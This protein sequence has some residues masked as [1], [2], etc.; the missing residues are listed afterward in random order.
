VM[1]AAPVAAAAADGDTMARESGTIVVPC[2][3]DGCSSGHWMDLGL[4]DAGGDAARVSPCQVS[5][6]PGSCMLGHGW[7]SE[8]ACPCSGDASGGP[9]HV[10]R[11]AEVE[12]D[13]HCTPVRQRSLP[14][15]PVSSVYNHSVSFFC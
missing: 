4:P 12:A 7:V 8:P 11:G 9:V 2:V 3:V 6:S 1:P 13:S 5:P 15:T 14:Q 10:P